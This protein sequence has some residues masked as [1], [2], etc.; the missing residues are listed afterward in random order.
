M[1]IHNLRFF[2]APITILC[3]G[4][5][6][7]AQAQFVAATNANGNNG[8]GHSICFLD[9][10]TGFVAGEALGKGVIQKTTDGA[11]TWVNVYTSTANS[12]WVND[13]FFVSSLK[14]Y[15]VGVSGSILKTTD[16][17]ANWSRQTVANVSEFKAVYFSS[18]LIGYAVG[19]GTKARCECVYRQYR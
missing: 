11:Q 13:I 3:V 7:P 9:A 6:Q 18:P 12:E 5:F 4:I 1:K 17:G 2:F 14:G 19:D 8:V 10:N 16:G 15:A